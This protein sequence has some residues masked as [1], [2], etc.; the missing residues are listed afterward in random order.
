MVVAIRQEVTVQP[1]G[2]IEVRS[3]EL[4]PGARAEVIVRLEKASADQAATV[5][6]PSSTASADAWDRLRRHAGAV[7]TDGSSGS[8]NESIDRDLAREYLD[9]HDP[10]PGD[11]AAD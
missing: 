3:P 11:P 10:T 4:T 6:E 9:P 7:S 1:G 5:G 2:V 8:D